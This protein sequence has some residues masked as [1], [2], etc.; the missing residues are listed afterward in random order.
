M[1]SSFS[2]TIIN[3]QLSLHLI[4]GVVGIHLAAASI[5]AVTNLSYSSF[6]LYVSDKGDMSL[7]FHWLE[8]Y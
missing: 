7:E 3:S 4:L 1:V 5:C 2:L 8:N 6:R